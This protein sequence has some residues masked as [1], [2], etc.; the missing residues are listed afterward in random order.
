MVLFTNVP[1]V[2]QVRELWLKGIGCNVNFYIG[3]DKTLFLAHRDIISANSTYFR[4]ALYNDGIKGSSSLN[5]EIPSVSAETFHT[6]LDF[7]YSTQ[8]PNTPLINSTNFV[9]LYFN[10]K[11]YGIASLIAAC[12]HFFKKMKSDDCLVILNQSVV[13]DIKDLVDDCIEHASRYPSRI[14][15][16]E[17]LLDCH[18][19]TLKILFERLN[20]EP[21]DQFHIFMALFSWSMA[22]CQRLEIDVTPE[23]E[24]KVLRELVDFVDQQQMSAD[25]KEATSKCLSL[26]RMYTLA[27]LDDNSKYANEM[28]EELSDAS[29][30]KPATAI[31]SVQKSEHPKCMVSV[32]P[33]PVIRG[34][35][36]TE[37]ANTAV[38]LEP[39]LMVQRGKLPKN[40]L[41]A[42]SKLSATVRDQKTDE[43]TRGFGESEFNSAV[44]HGEYKE[45]KDAFMGSKLGQNVE[46]K[47]SKKEF[48]AFSAT[49]EQPRLPE[50]P[51]ALRLKFAKSEWESKYLDVFK[52]LI[53]IA[54]SASRRELSEGVEKYVWKEN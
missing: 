42:V 2:L 25:D 3:F 50:T 35:K 54:C 43:K 45:K 22:E 49:N 28:V 47:K 23:N 19:S 29:R 9:A 24:R 40:A 38:S 12:Q 34:P 52:H 31:V 27:A 39:N 6:I 5:V 44:K 20:F 16:S 8:R 13:L 51:E 15:R 48:K 33:A 53:F 32:T 36:E 18:W 4:E 26:S 7:I 21:A 37:K 41:S 14:L 30:P 46:A 17:N 1:A 11:V 10:A